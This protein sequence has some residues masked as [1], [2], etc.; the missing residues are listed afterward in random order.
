[1]ERLYLLKVFFQP[2]CRIHTLVSNKAANARTKL[3]L[4]TFDIDSPIISSKPKQQTTE[5]H[6]Y[7]TKSKEHSAIWSEDLTQSPSERAAFSSAGPRAS[8]MSRQKRSAA[9][10]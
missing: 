6:G 5:R 1:M 9:K 3:I 7:L 10:Q 4:L 8:P 2:D